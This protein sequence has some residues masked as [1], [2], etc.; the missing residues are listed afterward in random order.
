MKYLIYMSR[1]HRAASCKIQAAIC[2]FEQKG[3]FSCCS[4]RDK[5]LRLLRTNLF[6]IFTCFA[7]LWGQVLQLI[8]P[9]SIQTFNLNDYLF[10]SHEL[11]AQVS[12]SDRLLSV[13]RPSVNFSHF[14]L[15]QN[16]WAN[17]NQTWHKAP[18]GKGDANLFK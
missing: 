4:I 9:S 1:R 11:K 3:M 5:G 16:N 17:F 18:F 15:L 12:F 14:H 8:V 2:P 10:S 7:N 13:V 6:N